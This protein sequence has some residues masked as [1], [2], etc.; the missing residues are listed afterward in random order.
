VAPKKPKKETVENVESIN[1]IQ[2][3]IEVK[4]KLRSKG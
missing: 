3:N 1:I 4:R 2:E